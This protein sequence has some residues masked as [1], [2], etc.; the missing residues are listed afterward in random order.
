MFLPDKVYLGRC[1]RLHVFFPDEFIASCFKVFFFLSTIYHSMTVL[2]RVRFIF[3]GS[4]FARAPTHLP[5]TG[6]YDHAASL[7]L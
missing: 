2:V 3:L 7:T 6:G 1:L 5:H 4:P